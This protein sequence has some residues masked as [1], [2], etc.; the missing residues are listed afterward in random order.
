M[1]KEKNV[2]GK[3]V[4]PI[5]LRPQTALI[6]GNIGTQRVRLLI[7]KD[8]AILKLSLCREITTKLYNSNLIV[9]INKCMEKYD[10]WCFQFL[11]SQL[12]THCNSV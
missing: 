1:R 4:F 10:M 7:F 12:E 6:H 5:Q 8:K 11:K 3:Q 9:Y 2:K